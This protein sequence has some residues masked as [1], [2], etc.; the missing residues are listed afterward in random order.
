MAYLTLMSFKTWMRFFLLWKHK[1]GIVKNVG[2]Q[3]VSVPIDFH[4][5]DYNNRGVNG[6]QTLLL[7]FFTEMHTVWNDMTECPF[8]VDC[9]FKVKLI[10]LL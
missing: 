3:M 5:M 1:R 2:N 7:T 8:W 6:N 4:Y 9:L 10:H